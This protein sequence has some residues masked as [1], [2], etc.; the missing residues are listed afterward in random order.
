MI[1]IAVSNAE[2]HARIV[3]IGLDVHVRFVENY[4]TRPTIGKVANVRSVGKC[5]TRNTTGVK[6]ANA[7]PTVDKP[8]K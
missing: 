4:V 3:T 5:A 2:K 8:G 7:V 6:I 1:A